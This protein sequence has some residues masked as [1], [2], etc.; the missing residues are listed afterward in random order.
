LAG[1][2][3]Q[4]EIVLA[5]GIVVLIKIIISRDGNQNGLI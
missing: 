2:L 3:D 5:E 1:D 4:A